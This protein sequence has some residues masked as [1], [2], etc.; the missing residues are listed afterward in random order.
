MEKRRFKTE[1]E[2]PCDEGFEMG[3]EDGTFEGLKDNCS[4]CYWTLVSGHIWEYCMQAEARLHK[5]R[6]GV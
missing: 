2:G 4:W 5:A 1:E 3:K 6:L